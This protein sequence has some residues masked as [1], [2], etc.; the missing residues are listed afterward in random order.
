[1]TDIEKTAKALTLN[2]VRSVTWW[3]SD[4]GVIHADVPDATKRG[5]VKRRLAT[6]NDG[7]CPKLNDDGMQVREFLLAKAKADED[8]KAQARAA[9]FAAEQKLRDEGYKAGQ[10]QMLARCTSKLY[11]LVYLGDDWPTGKPREE[12][13]AHLLAVVAESKPTLTPDQ[14]WQVTERFHDATQE[15]P[16]ARREWA[17]Q[18]GDYESM[19][20]ALESAGVV[21]LPKAAERH[22]TTSSSRSGRPPTRSSQASRSCSR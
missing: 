17:A 9:E 8:A 20:D 12:I 16:F 15:K 4:E 6:W 19:K 10:A 21:V 14:V 7:L 1:M 22:E 2:M 11:Q 13:W 3:C 18:S 5:L